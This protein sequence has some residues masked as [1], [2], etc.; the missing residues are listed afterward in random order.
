MSDAAKLTIQ[1]LVR[2]RLLAEPYFADFEIRKEFSGQI[3]PPYTSAWTLRVGIPK[4]KVGH[5][6]T[7]GPHDSEMNLAIEVVLIDALNGDNL[8]IENVCEILRA[9]LHHDPLDELAQAIVAKDSPTI[10]SGDGYEIKRCNFDTAGG[11]DVTRP[12]VEPVVISGTSSITL[13][14]ATAGAAIFY[15]LDGS[16]PSPRSGTR[17][18]APFALAS[19][20]TVKA[21]AW[22]AGYLGVSESQYTRP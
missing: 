9:V 16:H 18:T 21:T 6:E 2:D 22:L 20:E 10:E 13:S 7:P 8:Q 12:T 5:P 17:Y 15:T 1:T 4:G 19:G 3:E 11:I 14:C